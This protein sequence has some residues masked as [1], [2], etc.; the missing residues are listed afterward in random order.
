MEGMNKTLNNGATDVADTI[1]KSAGNIRD[2]VVGVA[3]EVKGAAKEQLHNLQQ[4]G[5]Q[6][7]KRVEGFVKERPLTSLALFVGLGFLAGAICRRS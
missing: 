5:S 1:R 4:E 6:Q 7:L 2:E 3:H